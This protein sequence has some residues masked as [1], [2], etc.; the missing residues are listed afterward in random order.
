MRG[1]N[2]SSD[3]SGSI[4]SVRRPTCQPRYGHGR[5]GYFASLYSGRAN[6]GWAPPILL[7]PI[8]RPRNPTSG[9]GLRLS[10]IKTYDPHR[11]GI[12]ALETYAGTGCQN[13]PNGDSGDD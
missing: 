3:I 10:P 6:A 9:G 7:A 12:V 2:G 4:Y 8:G 1:F 13:A 5:V 11:G